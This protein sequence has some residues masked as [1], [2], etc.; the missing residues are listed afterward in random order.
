MQPRKKENDV[1]VSIQQSISIETIATKS[2]DCN[3]GAG[4]LFREQRP[5]ETERQRAQNL[6]VS[7]IQVKE[8]S[9]GYT[10]G[11]HREDR[12]TDNHNY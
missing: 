1:D 6:S 11:T 8:T 10:T 12:G 7:H 5:R 3:E 2:I 4:I 9:E